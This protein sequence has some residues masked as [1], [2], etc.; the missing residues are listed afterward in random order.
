[1]TCD[2]ISSHDRISEIQS[3]LIAS[4]LNLFYCKERMTKKEVGIKGLGIYSSKRKFVCCS[5]W[6]ARRG[7]AIGEL[8]GVIFWNQ[9][10]SVL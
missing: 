2:V 4:L 10:G 3:F 7:E 1:M 5:C 8:V 9:T 6:N